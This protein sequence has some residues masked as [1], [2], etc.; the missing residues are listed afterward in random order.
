MASMGH[1]MASM[2]HDM[3]KGLEHG[4]KVALAATAKAGDLAGHGLGVAGHKVNV[5]AKAAG[6]AIPEAAK[7]IEVG[8]KAV[9]HNSSKVM[10]KA[11]NASEHV[12]TDGFRAAAHGLGQLGHGAKN[13][14]EVAAAGTVVAGRTIGRKVSAGAS[15]LKHG[16]KAAAKPEPHVPRLDRKPLDSKTAKGN[17]GKAVARVASVQKQVDTGNRP[18]DFEQAKEAAKARLGSFAKGPTAP[19]RNFLG[20]PARKM[21]DKVPNQTA[22]KPATHLMAPGRASRHQASPTSVSSASSRTSVSSASSISASSVSASSISATSV[23][24]SSVSA[25]YLSASPAAASPS[26]VS[27]SPYSVTPSQI[28]GRSGY[29]SHVSADLGSA[30]GVSARDDIS[31]VSDRFDDDKVPTVALARSPVSVAVSPAPTNRTGASQ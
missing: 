20:A 11:A 7:D 8:A 2:G 29:T 22:A 9:L 25:S 6:H 10:A 18:A 14:G 27:A 16:I 15:D 19:T 26:S 5:A 23:S 24:D 31:E 1:S 3:A 21:A 4:A 17:L 13:V 12:F 30:D 28:S